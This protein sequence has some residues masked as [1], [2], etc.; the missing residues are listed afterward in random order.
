MVKFN[1]PDTDLAYP[2]SKR[3]GESAALPPSKRQKLSK[4]ASTGR[5]II[6]PQLPHR[7]HRSI[8]H[9]SKKAPIYRQDFP[10]LRLSG[11]IR[12]KVYSH[13][14]SLN[15]I[16][17]YFERYYNT[18]RYYHTPHKM[19]IPS[20][21]SSTPTVLLINKKITREAQ[22]FLYS[23]G[24]VFDHGIFKI[25]EWGLNA[26]VSLKLLQNISTVTVT[27]S[28]HNF[29]E[30][31]IANPS[32]D[33]TITLLRILSAVFTFEHNLTS[34]TIAFK[35]PNLTRHLDHCWKGNWVCGFRDGI[36]K[37][38][39]AFRKVHNVR[40]VTLEGFSKAWAA[41]LT[42]CMQSP[43]VGFLDLPVKIR[44]RIYGLALNRSG[45]VD[46]ALLNDIDYATKPW[47]EWDFQPPYLRLNTP[48]VLLMNKQTSKEASEILAQQPLR[49]VM[50]GVADTW[51]Q[52]NLV[53][54]PKLTDFITPTTL[55][56]VR[57]LELDLDDGNWAF[58]MQEFLAAFDALTKPEDIL[59]VQDD[60]SSPS[61][62]A[63]SGESKDDCYCKDC[64]Y[65]LPCDDEG[66]DDES[67]SRSDISMYDADYNSDNEIS[68][69]AE[70]HGMMRDPVF[71]G[72]DDPTIYAFPPALQTLKITIS[73]KPMG[74]LRYDTEGKRQD[75]FGSHLV[76]M[77]NLKSVTFDGVMPFD[78]C[79]ELIPV[80]TG[81]SVERI[82]WDVSEE[83]SSFDYGD[84]AMS[85]D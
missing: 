14:F 29:M 80:M 13:C 25:S 75:L 52:V 58:V 12:N 6:S 43:P 28:G 82:S 47:L 30:K 83:G 48:T 15:G 33:G 50:H 62:C 32:W 11:E 51:R 61:N 76:R 81:S 18:I 67:D 60:A 24:I 77:R 71:E 26:V 3:G 16:K 39:L 73:G 37:E 70:A 59:V 9:F 68:S 2:L 44:N 17:T 53:K 79:S 34:L 54:M 38:M 21:K 66:Y 7:V 45:D 19:K 57:H 69:S 65:S 10:F 74:V 72:F 35:N 78:Y 31:R 84:C 64:Y 55:R 85:D 23:Q 36:K 41:D 1:I 5:Y 46:H 22:R 27:D 8:S 42:M 40:N 63:Y 49:I 20:L 4:N 56:N